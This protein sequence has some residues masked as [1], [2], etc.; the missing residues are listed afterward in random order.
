M[1]PSWEV[2]SDVTDRLPGS[3]R[4]SAVIDSSRSSRPNASIALWTSDRGSPRA[5]VRWGSQP[6]CWGPYPAARSRRT[7][8]TTWSSTS[9]TR[10][11]VSRR[12]PKSRSPEDRTRMGSSGAMSFHRQRFHLRADRRRGHQGQVRCVGGT[13]VLQLGPEACLAQHPPVTTY[14]LLAGL[15]RQQLERMERHR[16]RTASCP[17]PESSHYEPSRQLDPDAHTSTTRDGGRHPPE[18]S[19]RQLARV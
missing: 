9:T 11:R 14:D 1:S 2:A 6:G 7:V 10:A 8:A 17:C 4:R 19:Q 13:T 18:L 16:S 12:A 5:R 3:Q 15:V